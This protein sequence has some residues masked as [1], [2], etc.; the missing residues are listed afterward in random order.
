MEDLMDNTNE[1]YPVIDGIS[2]FTIS[3]LFAALQSD[4]KTL[5][6]YMARLITQN[7]TQSTEINNIFGQYHY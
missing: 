7:P 6:Q 3:Q 5:Q 4:V 2:G 1:N